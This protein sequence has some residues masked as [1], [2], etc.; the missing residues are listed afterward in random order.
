MAMAYTSA[1]SMLVLLLPG[2]ELKDKID[3]LAHTLVCIERAAKNWLVDD[4]RLFN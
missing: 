1:Y 4:I 3:R 2:S